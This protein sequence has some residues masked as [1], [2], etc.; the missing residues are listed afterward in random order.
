VNCNGTE[1]NPSCETTDSVTCGGS[2]T[3]I[4]TSLVPALAFQA[5]SGTLRWDKGFQLNSEKNKV[6]L[7]DLEFDMVGTDSISLF[8]GSVRCISTN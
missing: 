2:S 1:G 3:F 4:F 8:Q 7:A 6:V 5:K